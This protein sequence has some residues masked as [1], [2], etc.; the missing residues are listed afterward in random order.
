MK[1]PPPQPDES[2]RAPDKSASLRKS[3]GESIASPLSEETS[4]SVQGSIL[5]LGQ[6]QLRRRISNLGWSHFAPGSEAPRY[7]C[8]PL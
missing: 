1:G 4:R 5:V 3:V 2:D 6:A 7:N 8:F